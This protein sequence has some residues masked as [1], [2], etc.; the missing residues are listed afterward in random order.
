MPR[1]VS[2]AT[3]VASPGQSA[4]AADGARAVPANTRRRTSRPW[5]S[6]NASKQ[7]RSGPPGG[8]GKGRGGG[9]GNPPRAQEPAVAVVERVEAGAQRPAEREGV[10]REPRLD[11]GVGLPAVAFQGEQVVAAAAHDPLRDP[12]LASERVE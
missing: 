10:G 1:M 7:G 8:K 12:R 6:S 3:T 11:L 2:T 4:R 9:E 5:P